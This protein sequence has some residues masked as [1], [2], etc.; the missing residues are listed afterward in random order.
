MY[1]ERTQEM[2]SNRNILPQNIAN[3]MTRRKMAVGSDRTVYENG[4]HF[5]QSH[6]TLEKI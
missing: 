5:I 4:L 1:V 2:L 3:D 6:M